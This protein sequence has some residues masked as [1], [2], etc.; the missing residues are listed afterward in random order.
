MYMYMY[1]YE[2]IIWGSMYFIMIHVLS[3]PQETE[4]RWLNYSSDQPVSIVKEVFP[5]T[6]KGIARSCLG[7]VF[8][9]HEELD[10]LTESYHKCWLEMEVNKLMG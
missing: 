7:N 3:L 4:N 10:K 6:I 2:G 1:M 9:S 8:D 5:M